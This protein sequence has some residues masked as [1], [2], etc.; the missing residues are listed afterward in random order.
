[1]NIA[2]YNDRRQLCEFQ[3]QYVCPCHAIRARQRPVFSCNLHT[4]L[5]EFFDEGFQPSWFV[6]KTLLTVAVKTNHYGDVCNIINIMRGHSLVPE[7]ETYNS[8]IGLFGRRRNMGLVLLMLDDMQRDGITPNMET[9]V[10]TFSAYLKC[11]MFGQAF[12]Y[13]NSLRSS[14]TPV[15]QLYFRAYHDIRFA[16]ART[17]REVL[18]SIWMYLRSEAEPVGNEMAMLLLA[19]VDGHELDLVADVRRCG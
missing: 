13:M 14:G 18:Q 4:V 17:R 1:M 12:E 2:S 8:L 9:Y 7:L 16:D 6:Y 10:N 5:Q 11:R 15:T 19:A 3:A